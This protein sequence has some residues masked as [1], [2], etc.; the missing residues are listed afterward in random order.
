MF[1][2]ASIAVA[3]SGNPQAQSPSAQQA[4]QFTALIPIIMIVFVFYFLIIRPQ[5]KQRKEHA[6]MIQDLKKND[7]VITS[8]GVYA[9]IVAI[10]DETFVLRIAD[11]V[12]IEIQKG[13]IQGLKK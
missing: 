10:K 7:E 2:F 13:S 6:Q 8:G 5:K 4:S 1:S 12:K 9:T 11:D 3:L